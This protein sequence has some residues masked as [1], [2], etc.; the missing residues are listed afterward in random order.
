MVQGAAVLMI[1]TQLGFRAWALFPS[2]FYHDDYRLL[3]EAD[4]ERLTW[5]YL[6]APF[7]SQFMPL[8]RAVAWLVA[9]SGDLNWTLAASVTLTFQL[10]ASLACLWMLGTLFG[11]RWAILAPLGL[12]LSLAMTMPALMWWA[13]SLNQLP[14]QLA[15]FGGV[16]SWVHHLRT[17]QLKWLTLTLAFLG[18]G[19]LAYVKTVL[20]LGVLAFLLLAYFSEGGPGSRVWRSIRSYRMAGFAA[21]ALGIAY[22]AYYITQVPQIFDASDTPVAGGLA[23][24]MIG[25][26]LATG[27]LGG[28]WRWNTSNPPVGY[29][30]APLW[31]THAAWVVITLFALIC[32]LRREGTGRA[33]LLLGG[34]VGG[35]YL[36]LLTSRAALVG[37]IAGYEYRYLTDV[38]PVLALSLGL[39]TM[40]LIGAL[41]SSRERQEPMLTRVPGP[42]WQAAAVGIVCLSGCVS[43]W[44]YA[45]IWH[46]DNPGDSYIHAARSGL[47]GQGDVDVADQIVP[48]EVIPNFFFSYNTTRQLLPLAVKNV[49]FPSVTSD[50]VVL[51]ENGSPRRAQIDSVAVGRK[52]PVT[53]CGW[54]VRRAERQ[55]PLDQMTSDADWWVRIGYLSSAQDTVQVRMGASNVEAPV[56]RGLSS[57]YLQ[58]SGVIDSVTISGLSSG[59][60]LCVDT[61]EVGTPV[62]GAPL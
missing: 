24:H 3:G 5:A 39:V 52:G 22:V 20:V 49:R 35:A 27:A 60:T 23:D 48:S 4:G 10:A 47:R 40:P 42:R 51:D 46:H 61:I 19:L 58:A 59:T 57:L 37:P 26:S 56:Q 44:S 43:S 1:L 41:S 55:I 34:Y 62:P 50:L 14:M 25:S 45:E 31:T 12:Y 32:V 8:G 15:F 33:W 28:P 54:K 11:Y 36:L 18:V 30:D 13:A 29:F 6:L 38:V 16:A 21:S 2:W 53:D 9:Q 7:D 17:H